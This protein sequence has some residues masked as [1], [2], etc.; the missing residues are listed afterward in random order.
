MKKQSVIFLFAFF[1]CGKSS[2]K[3]EVKIGTQIWMT[4]NLDVSAF[5]NGDE[6]PEAKTKEEWETANN[7]KKPAW[8]LL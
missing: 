1:A 7:E 5:R 6:I 4:K 3:S 2:D 8:V